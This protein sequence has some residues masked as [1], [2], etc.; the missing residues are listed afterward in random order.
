[1]IVA[2]ILIPLVIHLQLLNRFEDPDT[3]EELSLSQGNV[4]DTKSKKKLR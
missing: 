4:N 2:L 3:D 1:M